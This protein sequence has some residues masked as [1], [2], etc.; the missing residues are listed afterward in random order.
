M[1][2]IYSGYK[3]STKQEAAIFVFEKK[4]LDKWTKRD[5]ES[6]IEILKKGVSQL[7]RLRHPRILTVQ[8]P[9]EESRDS[10]A[11]ATEPVFASLATVMG[12][13]DNMPQPIPQEMKDYTLHPIEVKLGLLQVCE[14]LTFLHGAKILHGNICPES[15]IINS[16]GAW[17]IFGLDFALTSVSGGA[18][19]KWTPKE[20]D[21]EAHALSQPHLDFMAPEYTKT[22]CS[23]ASDMY[24]L[25]MLSFAAFNDGK[26]LLINCSSWPIY[27]QNIEKLH[28]LSESRLQAAPPEMR[29]F[30]RRLVSFSP[31]QRPD[32]HE[33]SKVSSASTEIICT[34]YLKTRFYFEFSL[35]LDALHDEGVK[36]LN[37][38]DSLFQWDNL[39]KSKFY[40]GLADILPTLP[41]RVRVNRYGEYCMIKFSMKTFVAQVSH[42]ISL[43]SE[44]YHVLPRSLLTHQWFRLCYRMF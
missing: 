17:K 27:K 37:Y 42:F 8:H 30:I 6:M 31:S 14:G 16:Q 40:K 41:Q 28:D 36:T 35:Q 7:T 9:L 24:S 39:Q 13:F 4:Q 34:L 43:I 25:G 10:L 44:L 1:W 5:R 20:Y 21:P 19:G 22:E 38:L 15:I 18:D 29:N 11:F 3:K 23:T 12:C 33:F 2:K 26:A 32:S